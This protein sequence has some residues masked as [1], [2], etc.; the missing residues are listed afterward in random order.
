VKRGL[1]LPRSC[2]DDEAD[3]AV[4]WNQGGMGEGNGSGDRDFATGLTV[5]A[6]FS[7]ERDRLDTDKA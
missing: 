1:G 6:E 5:Q 4:D 7:R 3:M 2:C